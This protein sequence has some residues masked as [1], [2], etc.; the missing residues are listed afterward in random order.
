MS[1]SLFLKLHYKICLLFDEK[2]NAKDVFT[3]EQFIAFI[4]IHKRRKYVF[5]L[6]T[7]WPGIRH[8]D[9]AQRGVT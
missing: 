9:N 5:S 7:L 1:V 4:G 2:R 3:R 6:M 8:Y